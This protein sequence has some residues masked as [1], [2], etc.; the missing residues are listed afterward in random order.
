M[1]FLTDTVIAPKLVDRLSAI[2]Q[3]LVIVE[4]GICSGRKRRV[5]VAQGVQ[6]GRV[7]VRVKSIGWWRNWTTP[8]FAVYGAWAARDISAMRYQVLRSLPVRPRRASPALAD[9][10]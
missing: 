2:R 8:G 5:Q 7:E 1:N 9:G 6:G 10:V 4:N 3:V